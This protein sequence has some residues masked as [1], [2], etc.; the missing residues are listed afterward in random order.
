MSSQIWASKV[1]GFSAKTLLSVVVQYQGKPVALETLSAIAKLDKLEA[2]AIL[3][4]AEARG[5]LRFNRT[6]LAGEKHFYWVNLDV[7]TALDAQYSEVDDE[8]Q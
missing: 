1:L 3:R 7:I 8:P 5:I 4:D 6:H 2:L